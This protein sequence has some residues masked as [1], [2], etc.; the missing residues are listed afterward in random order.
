MFRRW[1]YLGSV[2]ALLLIGGLAIRWRGALHALWIVGPLIALGLQ[3]TLQRRQAVRRNWPLIGRFRY[4][5]EMIRPEI[6]QYFV[7]SNTDG[8][9]INREQRS[10]VY[11]RSK[12]VLDTL[13][14]GTQ[15][16]V[17]APGYEWIEHSIDALPPPAEEPRVRFGGRRKRPY[18]GAMLHVSAMSYGS[19]SR[20]A[21]LA[22]N[23]GAR[24]GGFAHNTGEGGL[25][26][27]HL[28]PGG[29]LIWQIGTGYFGCRNARGGFDLGAFRERASHP[30]VKMIEVKLSQ[31]A[32]PGHGGILPA[33]KVTQ[34]IA[35]IRGVPMGQDVLSP[36]AHTAFHTPLQLMQWLD[37][38]REAADGKPVGIK[39]CV[40]DPVELLALG[41]AIVRHGDGPDYIAVD[42]GEGGTGAAP[43]EFSNR[44]GTPLREGLIAV[45]NLLVGLGLDDRIRVVASGKSITGF[46]LFRL[47][48]LGADVAASARGMMFALGCIQARRCNSN[49]CPVGVATQNAAL[50]HGLDVPDK[51][52]R[53]T[54]YQHETVHAFLELLGAA[55]LQ[56][57]EEI[58]PHHVRRRV[59]GVVTKHYGELY[60]WLGSG[61]LL[62]A[63]ETTPW[64]REWNE[65]D[66][67]RFRR[68][69][70]R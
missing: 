38:L 67:E 23:E 9:P 59:D 1:F 6:Q 3:D 55:G 58:R 19:L 15:R 44:V 25:S 48:A 57:P 10:I 63:P 52:A 24:R 13:P 51:A 69:G 53:V 12:R 50:V 5:F 61:Q 37:D 64:A 28:E 22:L 62:E 42:G 68:I 41:K 8:T 7:E 65:A 70:P 30:H 39:L 21:I 40:G 32:K 46:H 26:P 29:D 27:Y 49:E 45:R 56:R 60:D 4:L 17:Y 54:S 35:T 31:G 66:P 34:E 36:P 18:D 43:L 2:V 20:N 33:V 47:R 14:F 16:D 11:Q